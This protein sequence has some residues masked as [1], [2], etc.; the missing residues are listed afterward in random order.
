MVT[1][2]GCS[3]I[4]DHK[5][6]RAGDVREDFDQLRQSNPPSQPIAVRPSELPKI[7]RS[8][9]V[10]RIYRGKNSSQGTT[11]SHISQSSSQDSASDKYS[12]L[13][14][15]LSSLSESISQELYSLGTQK[16]QSQAASQTQAIPDDVL[17]ENLDITDSGIALKSSA[18]IFKTFHELLGA[19]H[20]GVYTISGLN[21]AVAIQQLASHADLNIAI[22]TSK[23]TRTGTITKK[24]SAS[25]GKVMDEMLSDNGLGLIWSSKKKRGWVIPFSSVNEIDSRVSNLSIKTKSSVLRSDY[26]HLYKLIQ[27]AQQLTVLKANK[28]ITDNQEKT[29]SKLAADTV[30]KLSV[31]TKIQAS[32][33]LSNFFNFG[34][35]SSNSA[36]LTNSIT[37]GNAALTETSCL[38]PNE[39]VKVVKIFTAYNKPNEVKK[40]LSDNLG[41]L[42]KNPTPASTPSL[43]NL[44]SS[45]TSSTSAVTPPTSTND[46]CQTITQ[47]SIEADNSGIIVTGR[48]SEISFINNLL[49]GVDSPKKQVLVEVYLVQVTTDWRRELASQGNLTFGDYRL[50]VAD[51]AK[52]T[53]FKL[54][55]LGAA[56][57]AG[58]LQ[59]LEQSEIGK[60]IS[61]P[62]VLLL[63]GEKASVTRTR[64]LKYIEKT[65]AIASATDASVITQPQDKY[66][67]L[68]LK[69]TLNIEA[70]VVPANNHVLLDFSLLEDTID[71]ESNPETQGQTKNDIKTKIETSPGDV[72][73]LAGLYRQTQ[74]NELDSLPGLGSLKDLNTVFGGASEKTNNQS[75]L[76]IFIAPTVLE[77]GQVNT[78]T[79]SPT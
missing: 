15:D 78:K 37:Q 21:V 39:T 5:K 27:K 49:D 45:D 77:P 18:S 41:S 3:S 74:S 57:V 12:A 69:L 6:M 44:Q 79:N 52:G 4:P 62:S 68:E 13:V 42:L 19:K 33:T 22:P 76:L 38:K 24:V 10:L 56:S 66:V 67:D 72:V 51:V 47:L 1:L 23:E 40:S 43:A 46:D 26:S 63:D 59:A 32:N 73:V 60:T 65:P 17:Q 2:V 71:S 53:L 64:V 58:V 29:F 61:S 16:N 75:E 11:V 30:A 8:A 14:N 25:L 50:S 31:N 54:N 20:V 36:T 55:G 7:Q 35:S 34:S 70:N 9:R 28:S 48:D